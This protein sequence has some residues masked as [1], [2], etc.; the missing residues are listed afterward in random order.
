MICK[1]VK[2]NRRP[3]KLLILNW[4]IGRN[5]IISKRIV[6]ALRRTGAKPPCYSLAVKKAAISKA[7]ASLW[8]AVSEDENLILV[9]P[10]VFPCKAPARP[11]LG[12]KWSAF[13]R[14]GGV[15]SHGTGKGQAPHHPINL[16]TYSRSYW[17]LYLEKKCKKHLIEKS[18]ANQNKYENHHH[19][20]HYH[21]NI[22]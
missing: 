8:S 22:F 3:M 13:R 16:H 1:K 12:I 9:W 18:N 17:S 10:P 19:Y 6:F 5:I 21:N 4:I 15:T 14:R 7:A 11:R 20:H 2:Q